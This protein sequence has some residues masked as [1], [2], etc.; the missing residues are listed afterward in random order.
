[1]GFNPEVVLARDRH[2]CRFRFP[3]VCQRRATRVMLDGPEFLGG[4][5][6]YDN[7]RAVCSR[8][9]QAQQELRERAAK[10]CER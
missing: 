6:S 10:L 2:A 4:P 9:A 1:M 3:S 8:C 7:A 5:T